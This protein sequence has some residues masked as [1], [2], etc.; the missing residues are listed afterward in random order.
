MSST[1]TSSNNET[2]NTASIESLVIAVSVN[3]SRLACSEIISSVVIDSILVPSVS[4]ICATIEIESCVCAESD[5][6]I[7]IVIISSSAVIESSREFSEVIVE[8]ESLA[9]TVSSISMK[10]SF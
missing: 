1:I 4:L 3:N 10:T 8:I 9:V 5:I 7:P 2:T 6:L